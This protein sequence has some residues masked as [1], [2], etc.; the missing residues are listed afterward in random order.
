MTNQ[1]NI[2][3]NQRGLVPGQRLFDRYTLQ[4]ILSEDGAAVVWLATDQNLDR[5]VAL[6]FL[7]EGLINSSSALSKAIRRTGK[8]VELR[9][10]NIVRI[11]DFVQD[12]QRAAV[13]M[14]RIEGT[15]LTD[16]RNARPQA[17]FE[18]DDLVNW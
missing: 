18:T 13:S 1:M 2:G 4:Y 7:P 15:A 5:Q 9:H 14:E 11:Y 16:L 17:I 6:H 8:C 3:P 12:D 10:K